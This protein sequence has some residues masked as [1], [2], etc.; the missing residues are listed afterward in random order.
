MRHAGFL[1][2]LILLTACT[3]LVQDPPQGTGPLLPPAILGTVDS[4]TNRLRVGMRPAQVQTIIGASQETI[5]AIGGGRC[6][7]YLYD[8]VIG[9]KYVHAVF[10]DGALVRASDG[11][12]TPCSGG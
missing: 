7:S 2:A 12:P 3:P 8:E 11:H 4:G 5:P 10:V 6:L 9:A 1:S